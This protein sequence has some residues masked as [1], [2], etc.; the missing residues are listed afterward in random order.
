ML[1]PETRRL[2]RERGPRS[3]GA[4]QPGHSHTEEPSLEAKGAV[5]ER[6]TGGGRQALRGVERPEL[7]GQLLPTSQHSSHREQAMEEGAGGLLPTAEL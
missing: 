1:F 3:Q 6:E 4:W 7:A 2:A 5:F